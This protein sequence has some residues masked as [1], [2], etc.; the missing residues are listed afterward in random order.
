MHVLK[1]QTVCNALDAQV[2]DGRNSLAQDARSE[3]DVDLIH[4]LGPQE[5]GGKLTSALD[6]K[7]GN[8]LFGG[9]TG[10]VA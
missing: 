5:G 2:S 3:V 7:T 9:A 4:Q 6:N 1:R 8:V 10:K